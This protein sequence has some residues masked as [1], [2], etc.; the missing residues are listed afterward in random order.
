MGINLVRDMGPLTRVSCNLYI[1]ND[2]ISIKRIRLM[3]TQIVS[4]CSPNNNNVN[5]VAERL[6]KMSIRFSLVVHTYNTLSLSW[7]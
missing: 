5:N 1:I 4:T 6:R 3:H 2:K 7:D